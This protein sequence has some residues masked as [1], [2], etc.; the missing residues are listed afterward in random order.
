MS[1]YS[2]TVHNSNFSIIWAKKQD[3]INE[4]KDHETRFLQL[5]TW[6]AHCSWLSL[7]SGARR[8]FSV[9]MRQQTSSSFFL[10]YAIW[11]VNIIFNIATSILLSVY[12]PK[13]STKT[14]SHYTDSSRSTYWVKY[15]KNLCTLTVE[16]RHWHALALIRVCWTQVILLTEQMLWGHL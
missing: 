12:L 4:F 10:V 5:K 14:M 9:C 15:L 11:R 2:I 6:E 1:K 7:F 13:W 16:V 8:H 3:I